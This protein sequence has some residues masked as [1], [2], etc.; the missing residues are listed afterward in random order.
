[1]P[2]TPEEFRYVARL[3]KTKVPKVADSVAAKRGAKGP[4]GKGAKK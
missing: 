2:I 1:M 3:G 4:G